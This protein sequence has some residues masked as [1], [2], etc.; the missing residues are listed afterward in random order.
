MSYVAPSEYKGTGTYGVLT[1]GEKA[2]WNE[3]TNLRG[4]SDWPGFDAAQ[5]NRRADSRAWLLAR[6]D[7]IIMLAHGEVP[8]STPGWDTAHRG[9]RY[10]YISGLNSGSPKHEVRLPCS[11][12]ATDTE[13]VYIEE[14]EVYLAFGSEYESQTARKQANV[15]WLVT[16]RKKLWHLMEDDPAANAA[17][18]RQTRYDNLCIATHHGAVY[19][20]WA[21]THN[22]WG[23]PLTPAG[24]DRD[25]CMEWCK[26]HL[27]VSEN[28]PES[29]R[30]AP[31]PDGWEN[32]VYGSS[33]V[34][35][36]ACFAVCSA[37]DNGV[38]GSGTAGCAN[39]IDLAK[40]GQGIYQGYTT[41]ATKVRR[42]DHFFIGG[43][44]TGVVRSDDCTSSSIP[45]YEGNTSPGSEGSQ[46]NGGCVA[47]RTRSMSGDG[48]T[49]F[50]LV[51]FS[52]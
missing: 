13:K 1:D 47:Q 10:D 45:S 36:C 41:D 6:M 43:N 15:D 51:R 8:D 22:K 39:N 2:T 26:A 44:H 19:E 50:G 46:Y 11:G 52:E 33:G 28:P 17:N 5:D 4:I 14:R 31:Q 7:Y 12:S 35:W 42:G 37:W 49:G 48:V 30:G 29:N 27:G 23:V 25:A 18:D 38:S 16:R 9:E 40:K 34:P 20:D 24:G 21:V 3:Y 32:R